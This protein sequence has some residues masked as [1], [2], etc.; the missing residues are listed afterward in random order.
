MTRV[1]NEILFR[2]KATI[3]R[4]ISKSSALAITERKLEVLVFF[5]DRY[6]IVINNDGEKCLDHY[7]QTQ[8]VP[9]HTGIEAGT[10]IVFDHLNRYGEDDWEVGWWIPLTEFQKHS[11]LGD[12]LLYITND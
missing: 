9:C 4:V 8:A 2:E 1:K 11:E 3:T 12:P 6:G 5:S 10:E 7:A